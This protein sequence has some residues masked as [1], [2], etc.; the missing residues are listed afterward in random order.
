MKNM[1]SKTKWVTL[2]LVFLTIISSTAYSGVELEV[3]YYTQ[4]GSGW[5]WATS[6]AMMLEAYGFRIKPWRIAAD[7]DKAYD[8]GLSW[9]EYGHE[10]HDYL[11]NY[12]NDGFNDA[13]NCDPFYFND[14]SIKDKIVEVLSSGHPIWAVY[15]VELFPVPKPHAIVITGYDG[16]GD[17]DHIFVHDPSYS[18]A[19]IGGDRVYGVCTW[20]DFFSKLNQNPI[21]G[22]LN[23]MYARPNK[24]EL[25]PNRGP[26]SVE[27]EPDYLIFKSDGSENQNKCLL[28][29][30][31]GQEP[32]DGYRYE[33]GSEDVDWPLDDDGDAYEYGYKA[34]QTSTLDVKPTYSYSSLSSGDI[35]FRYK[36]SIYS[37]PEYSLV[38]GPVFTDLSPVITEPTSGNLVGDNYDYIL[39]M[40]DLPEGVYKLEVA[41]TDETGV[42]VYDKCSFKFGVIW[43]G[44]PLTISPYAG[45]NGDI[46]PSTNFTV[47]PLEDVT[48]TATPIN[49]DYEVDYW[50]VQYSDHTETFQTSEKIYT[51]QNVTEDISVFVY[52]K[53]IDTGPPPFGDLVVTRPATS[54]YETGE[55]TVWFILRV[56]DGTDKVRWHNNLTGI[57]E[58]KNVNPDG[59]WDEWIAVEESSNLIS[60]TAYDAS[61]N[62]LAS[63]SFTVIRQSNIRTIFLGSDNCESA[64]F[65]EGD[66]TQHY[67]GGIHIGWVY[68]SISGDYGWMEG[69]V[70]FDPIDLPGRVA[71][72]TITAQ[73]RARLYEFAPSYGVGDFDITAA[74]IHS[75]WAYDV[76]NVTWNRR[77]T[78]VTT[79][80]VFE[81][82]VYINSLD[83]TNER[84]VYF[85]A[86]QA[87]ENWVSGVLNKGFKLWASG[88]PFPTPVTENHV[89]YFEGE[90]FRLE[91][92]YKYITIPPALNISSPANN[93]TVSN[94]TTSVTVSGTTG[95][96]SNTSI[97]NVTWSNNTTGTSGTASGTTSWSFSVNL[98]V[99]ANQIAVTATDAVDNT[100]SQ[101]ITINRAEPD[102][103]PPSNPS[104]CST[105]P[106]PEAIKLSWQNP[107][108]P[109]FTG[110]VI[111][112]SDNPVSV[113]LTSGST[114]TVGSIVGNAI[115]VYVGSSESFI[116]SGLTPF[117]DYYFSIHSFDDFLNYSGGVALFG[118][119]LPQPD[120]TGEGAVNLL[121]FS[122]LA[123]NWQV[124]DCNELNDWCEK[125]DIDKSGA[126][127]FNDLL[128]ICEYWLTEPEKSDLLQNMEFETDLAEWTIGTNYP[129]QAWDVQ[130]SEDHGGSAKMYISKAPS[131]ASISQETQAVIMP[132][133]QLTV[134][135]YH[136]NMGDFS[137]WY[138]LIE[139]G[140]SQVLLYGANGP[141]GSDSVTWT[142]D[143][144]YDPG[145][146]ISVGCSVWPGSSTTWVKSITYNPAQ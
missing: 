11:E 26:L 122:V 105:T 115:V 14:S 64:D 57:E 129:L 60:F 24:L 1:F 98:D 28:F 48:F 36:Y 82:N 41:I 21:T 70:R 104:N 17:S 109:D 145:T 110:V 123:K 83:G 53:E 54:P 68:S 116:D 121:D 88:R 85:E 84:N 94:T 119:P 40:C 103:T 78:T 101:M 81:K 142:A 120:I 126:V 15:Y 10:F 5:C 69:V 144:Q 138:L 141:E 50:A 137:G 136:S 89:R 3:P 18:F 77:P 91:I 66:P 8:E 67:D 132:G 13:W 73:L 29:K 124:T 76:S 38:K 62:S 45:S 37:V 33:P 131:Q 71:S 65:W 135:V 6:C 7:F 43:E 63:T 51:H 99:G 86:S 80:T 56:P 113:T 19:G 74:A 114:Y 35:A 47:L 32:Y 125:A 108:N 93:T 31:D 95:N 25:Y 49:D 2:A 118:V 79:G 100:S 16:L 22:D 106:L 39:P 143:R 117:A 111:L 12:F 127:D 92:S 102:T 23:L 9:L 140:P 128:I 134:N 139:P 46:S 34:L 72:S 59:T 87:V 20:T 75:S 107:T 133:D 44:D 130:W 146:L 90:D 42:Q 61:N 55:D 30:W 96:N 112:R 52:F 4:D 58:D 27:V 97:S